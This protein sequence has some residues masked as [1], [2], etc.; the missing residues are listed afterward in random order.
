[1]I[2]TASRSL[3]RLPSQA[4]HGLLVDVGHVVLGQILDSRVHSVLSLSV[5]LVRENYYG[6]NKVITYITEQSGALSLVKILCSDWLNLTML[7]PRFM[8]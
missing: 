8:P 5:S 6:S 7:V 3:H 2:L 1:M 4:D